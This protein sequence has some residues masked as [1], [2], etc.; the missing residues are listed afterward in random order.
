MQ[1]A[2]IS[3][4]KRRPATLGSAGALASIEGPDLDPI[5]AAARQRYLDAI[6]IP[7]A[8]VLLDRDQPKIAA[9]NIPFRRIGGEDADGDQ[10]DQCALIMRV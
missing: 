9:C 5:L 4:G 7:A 1:V 6:H 10:A 3:R 8:V 2:S